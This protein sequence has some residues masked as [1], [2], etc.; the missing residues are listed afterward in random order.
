MKKVSVLKNRGFIFLEIIISL[1]LITLLV[2]PFYKFSSFLTKS[3]KQN[4][5]GENIL[6]EIEIKRKLSSGY[7]SLILEKDFL[8]GNFSNIGLSSDSDSSKNF[9]FFKI[10]DPQFN[11]ELFYISTPINKYSDCP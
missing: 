2:I 8:L 6:R 5:K 1:T 10:K 3:K 11:K 9:I 7:D 4:S